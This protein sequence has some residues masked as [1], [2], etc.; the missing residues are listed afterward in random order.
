MEQKN[1][2][3]FNRIS[4][5]RKNIQTALEKAQRSGD[6]L[7]LMA[8]TKTVDVENVNFA[9]TCGI[10]LFGENRVQEL[11]DKYDGYSFKKDKIHFIGHLQTNKVKYIIDKVSMIESVDTIK[12][13]QEIDKLSNQ[14]SIIMPILLQIN[15]AKEPTKNGFFF[16][17]IDDA[18]KTISTYK[19]V[20]IMGLMCIPPKND[21]D[22]SFK[23]MNDLFQ[24]YKKNPI[25]NTNFRYLSMGMSDTY[26]N[27][28]QNNS[29]IVRIGNA[30]FSARKA[31]NI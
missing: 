2:E 11:L 26:E 8:V 19:N 3:I 4:I 15:T 14:N 21:S 25:I 7:T 18:I 27:A 22:S 20:K 6:D 28:I 13:A 12:L 24:S 1:E 29:N 5:I 23:K 31:N 9:A 16:E 30:M 17:E 10:S